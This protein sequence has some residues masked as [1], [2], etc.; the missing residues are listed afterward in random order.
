VP[1]SRG[2]LTI[3]SEESPEELFVVHPAQL[4]RRRV[5]IVGRPTL[6]VPPLTEATGAHY[7]NI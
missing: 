5:T 2:G 3:D 4:G 1:R 6:A 7:A